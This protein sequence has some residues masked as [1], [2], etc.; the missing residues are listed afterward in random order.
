MEG[1]LQRGAGEAGTPMLHIN[2]QQCGWCACSPSQLTRP[3]ASRQTRAT[4]AAFVTAAQTAGWDIQQGVPG[5]QAML[6]Q[7]RTIQQAGKGRTGPALPRKH[8]RH[9]AT[10]L[11]AVEGEQCLGIV[12]GGRFFAHHLQ[13]TRAP[14]G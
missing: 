1:W 11:Q 5:N 12:T 13:E 8:P 9:P 10:H 2:Q 7:T 14:M 4:A 3:A 6:P